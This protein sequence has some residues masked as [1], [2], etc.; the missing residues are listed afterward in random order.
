MFIV[1][2]YAG[3]GKSFLLLNDA[4][5]AWKGGK[6]VA[7]ATGEMSFKKYR[8]R[9]VALHS[10]E[11]HFRLNLETTKID[12]GKLSPEEH[13]V[14]LEVLEDI[15]S[16]PKYGKVFVFQFPF[17]A[18]PSLIFNK[19]SSYDQ[20]VPLDMAVI[21]YLG[22]MSSERMRV[23]RREELDDL[24]RET[25]AL[26][27]DFG[28]GRGIPLEAAYQVNRSS[29]ETA[30]REGYYTLACFSDSAEAEKSAD[31]ALWILSI[32][33]N[34]AELKMGFIKNRDDALGEHFFVKSNLKNAQITSLQTKSGRKK[35]SGMDLLDV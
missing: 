30:M 3:V 15:R 2:A 28:D 5:S 1:T 20:I 26:G 33:Q 17:R 21:D 8:N 11:P 23:S 16:N 34:P 24:I 29:F 18:T 6:N 14:Y 4:H 10:C 9:F 13:E 7:I 27:L 19:F 22:L 35:T 25:K 31:S 12:R 32:P